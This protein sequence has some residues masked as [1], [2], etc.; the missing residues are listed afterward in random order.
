MMSSAEKESP[1]PEVDQ[2]KRLERLRGDRDLDEAWRLVHSPYLVPLMREGRAF[3]LGVIIATQFP[4]DLPAEI[5]GSAATKLFFSQTRRHPL[6]T[7]GEEVPRDP[8][9]H[10]QLDKVNPGAW[11]GKQFAH[12]RERVANR[13]GIERSCHEVKLQSQ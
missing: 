12:R 7:A 9:G 5:A 10:V 3:G 13:S 4:K 8:F 11:F 1:L 6:L 2:R